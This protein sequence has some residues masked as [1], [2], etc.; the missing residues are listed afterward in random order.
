[1]IDDEP[2][3]HP[4]R[5]GHESGTIREG[6]ALPGGDVEVGLVQQGGRAERH[7]RPAARELAFRES[8]QFGMEPGEQR[9]A[10]RSVASLRRRDQL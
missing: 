1:V 10:S 9:L 3:H 5:V 4:R 6:R 8:P 7:L 2:A